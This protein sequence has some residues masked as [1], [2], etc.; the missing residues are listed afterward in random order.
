MSISWQILLHISWPGLAGLVL[1]CRFSFIFGTL[2]QPASRFSNFFALYL[3]KP[4]LFLQSRFRAAFGKDFK[5]RVPGMGKGKLE[6]GSAGRGK[7]ATRAVKFRKDR[8]R[9]RP[10]SAKAILKSFLASHLKS[11]RPFGRR[12]GRKGGYLW[13]VMASASFLGTHQPSGL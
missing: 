1:T 13:Q 11:G 4:C 10:G 3:H 5:A 2:T 8:A 12:S 7:R 9:K 6:E